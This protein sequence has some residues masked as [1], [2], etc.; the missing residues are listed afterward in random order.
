MSLSG[1]R[2]TLLAAFHEF[3]K[4]D[5]VRFPSE[6]RL[7]YTLPALFEWDWMKLDKCGL[8]SIN[9]CGSEGAVRLLVIVMR[10][11]AAESEP[12]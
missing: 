5:F 4:V 8:T 2:V 6:F 9:R 12:P 7:L 10:H 11:S 1:A 3:I